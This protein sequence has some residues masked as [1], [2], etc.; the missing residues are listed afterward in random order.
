MS[1]VKRK[2]GLERALC[3]FKKN[4]LAIVGL[5]IITVEVLAALFAPVLAPYPQDAGKHVDFANQLVPPGR[6]HLFGTD[7]VGRDILSRVLFGARISLQLAATVLLFAVL[8]GVPL[9]IAAGYFGGWVEQVIMRVTDMFLALPPLVFA[10]AISAVLRP[11]LQS[12]ILAISFVWWRGFCRLAYGETLSL[13]QEDYVQ[14][15]KALGASDWHIM[16]REILPNMTSPILVKISLDA[17]YAILVGTAISFLGLGAQPP[18]PE[19]GVMISEGRSY[20]PHAWWPSLFPGLA[21]FATVLSFNFIGDG[22]RDFFD[23]DVN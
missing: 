4:K 12:C 19:W 2:E 14:A 8:I 21:I 7:E 22:L 15:A 18:T 1:R 5:V 16:I 10:L 13:K 17:G 3:R 6:E 20:L 9:G 11:S 23:V